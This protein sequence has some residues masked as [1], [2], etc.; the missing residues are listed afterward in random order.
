VSYG[1]PTDLAP[2]IHGIL[3]CTRP[4]SG[5]SVGSIAGRAAHLSTIRSKY[6]C[7]ERGQKAS[8][9]SMRSLFYIAAVIPVDSIKSW[10]A[11]ALDSFLK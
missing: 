6:L 11:I 8:H 1:A 2:A 3:I 4:V 7:G 9:A 5:S 10:N